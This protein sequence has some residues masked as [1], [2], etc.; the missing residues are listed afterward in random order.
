MQATL[1]GTEH[2]SLAVASSSSSSVISLSPSL[3][4]PGLLETVHRNF[5]VFA[6][7][8]LS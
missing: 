8:S 7:L 4:D 2:P 6:L 1:N 5:L 3:P